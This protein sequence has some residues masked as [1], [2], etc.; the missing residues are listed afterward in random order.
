MKNLAIPAIFV[1]AAL[2]A[3]IVALMPVEEA[4]AVHTTLLANI[5]DQTRSLYFTTDAGADADNDIILVPLLTGQ[6]FA[7]H[8]IVTSSGTGICQVQTSGGD[9]VIVD[10]TADDT[11]VG[12]LIINANAGT[13]NPAGFANTED[14]QL[15]T[16]IDTT[17]SVM[18]VVTQ[19]E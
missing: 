4:S 11:V 1:A 10:G 6:A 3:G 12:A 17:C 14:I 8:V 9:D 15:D 2:V 5:Q 7:G 18:M 19:L 13:P 16:P